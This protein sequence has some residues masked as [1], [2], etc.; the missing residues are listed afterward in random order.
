MPNDMPGEKLC[1]NCGNI[2]RAEGVPDP[3]PAGRHLGRE[4][5]FW[6]ALAVILAFLLSASTTGERVGG[7]GAIALLIWFQRR[8]RRSAAATGRT[9]TGRYRCDYCQGRFEGDD[10]RDISPRRTEW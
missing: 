10:L 9:G 5:A 2:L 6:L 7:L 1:P 3:V 8:L 4:L